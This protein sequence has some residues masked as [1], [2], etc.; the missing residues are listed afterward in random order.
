MTNRKQSTRSPQIEAEAVKI[1][2]R[3]IRRKEHGIPES[4]LP[5]KELGS[6]AIPADLKAGPR[7]Y[8]CSTVGS[9]MEPEVY[10]GDHVI[11]DPDRAPQPGDKCV[12]WIE[13]VPK[14][15]LK[16]LDHELHCWPVHPNSELVPIIR[17][18]QINPVRY[19][20]IDG[21]RLKAIHP[22]IH[23]V[24]HKRRGK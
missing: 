24:R 15:V 3:A 18:R 4:H 5:P 21:E 1:V 19:Y 22:V 10:A 20:Q 2:R 23:V 17:V 12:F 7:S 8:A 13:G 6:V 14:P 9:C 11:A 16:V